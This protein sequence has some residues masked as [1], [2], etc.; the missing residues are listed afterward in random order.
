MDWFSRENLKTVN[1]R[2]S[3]EKYG[4]ETSN[5]P[6]FYQSIEEA[7]FYNTNSA[8]KVRTSPFLR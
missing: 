5:F 7:S 4:A 1:H 3:P 2:F 6:I 8:I